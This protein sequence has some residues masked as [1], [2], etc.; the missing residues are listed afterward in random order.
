MTDKSKYDKLGAS[1]SK[2]GIHEALEK[3]GASSDEGLFAQTNAD[4]AGDKDYR[5]FLHC[6]GA[7][8]KTIVAYLLYRETGDTSVFRGLAQDALVMNLDDVFCL[9]VPEDL[10]LANAISRNS[11]VVDDSII[12]QIISSYLE[13]AEKLIDLGIPISISGG[14]TADCGDIVRTLVVDAVL[15]GRINNQEIINPIKLKS[16]DVI[17]GLSGTGQASYEDK[18]NSSIGS[19]GL[20]LARHTLI[21]NDYISKFPEVVDP[22]ID[23]DVAYAGPYSVTEVADGLNSTVGEALLSPTRTYAPVLLKAYQ[24]L[25]SEVHGAIHCTGG[26]QTKVLRFGN[27]NHY[28]KD[29]LF[30][31]PPL[32]ELIQK[33]GEVDWQEMYQVFNMG[34]RMELYVPHASAKT[35]V[36]IAKE[37]SIEAKTIGFVEGSSNGDNSVTIDSPQ[38][39][40]TYSL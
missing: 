16:G 9:G 1:A 14:E 24:E 31:I 26:G 15:A 4:I 30:D 13:L 37:F 19:N 7:G 10:L 21:K 18:P 5:S 39:K 8:T 33:E 27:G 32:F 40:F 38:G 20:T 17:I 11:S 25:G 12:E 36:D 3:A 34:H 6:D 23:K 35:I 28:I 22:N 2:K 29:N